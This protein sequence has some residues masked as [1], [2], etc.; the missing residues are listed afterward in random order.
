M[1]QRMMSA[2]VKAR[3][4]GDGSNVFLFLVRM[5]GG[6]NH[7][8]KL[9]Q[10]RSFTKMEFDPSGFDA[11]GLIPLAPFV[12]GWIPLGS[13]STLG[14]IATFGFDCKLW[15]R[16]RWIRLRPFGFDSFWFDWNLWVS[17]PLVRFLW[18]RFLRARLLWIPLD[19]IGACGFCFLWLVSFGFDS[20]GFD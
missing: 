20:F 11:V 2:M 8:Q 5:I 18:V 16:F 14:S 4:K 15:F 13:G 6:L 3:V 19:S 9:S 17:F 12:L 10:H 7:V 1:A